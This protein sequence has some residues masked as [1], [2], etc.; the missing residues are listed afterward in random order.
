[1][2]GAI[3]A[4]KNIVCE[5]YFG[6]RLDRQTQLRRVKRV[7]A[8]ELSSSQKQVVEG[9]YYENLTQAELARRLGVNRSTVCRTLRRAQSRI[10]RCLAY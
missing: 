5:E 3:G 9:I 6:A 1:M 2:K 10:R 4:M 7:I 8:R